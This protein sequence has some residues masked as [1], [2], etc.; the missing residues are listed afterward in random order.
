M[1]QALAEEFLN[2]TTAPLAGIRALAPI[3]AAESFAVSW[4]GSDESGILDYDV[5]V[6]ILGGPWNDWL[7]HTKA[8]TATYTGADGHGF[9]F[10]VRARDTHGNAGV[11]DV[12]SVYHSHVTLAPGAFGKV[13]AA[14]VNVRSAAGTSAPIVTTA[15]SG[16]LLAITGG[17]VTA[18]G[19]TWYRA[20]LPIAEWAPIAGVR[21]DVWVAA[22]N[23]SVTYVAPVSAPNATVVDL[24]S[25]AAP[26]P[27]ARFVG[28]DP[29]RILDTRAGVGLAGTFASGVARTFRV[30]GTHGIPTNA[31]AVTGTLTVVGQSSAG[32]ASLGPSAATVARSSVV[33]VPA[34]DVR[35][36]GVTVKLGADG[37]L[38]ALWTGSA[39]SKS[40]LVFDVS[41]YFVPGATGATFA[42]ITPSRVL[43]TR[44]ANGL[45]GRFA[46]NVP[47]AFLVRGRGGVP[48]GAVAVTGNLTVVGP[49]SAGFL[50]VGP[51]ASTS[52]PGSSLNV[53]KGDIRAASVTVKLDGGGRL[54]VVWKGGPG[55][56][57]DVLFDVTGYFVNGGGGATYHP[58]DAARVLDSR[59]ANGLA[60][61]FQSQ[62]TRTFQATGR[63]TIP[64]NA[65]AVTGGATI[66]SPTGN[67]LLIIGP[68]GT[69][70]GATSTVNLP[71][72][73]I[74]ANGL[75]VRTGPG[76]ALGVVY[77]GPRGAS[78]NVI[79]DATGYFR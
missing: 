47:R 64:V 72:G 29:A 8:T 28:I 68:A 22:G 26:A 63:G 53:P 55:A 38:A 9:A 27:G 51:V 57:A 75:T 15:A 50:Y 76:G 36:A 67:G 39:G 59:I 34:R 65:V 31:V 2:D 32:F 73:D 10:R 79:F 66:V 30:G 25:G 61:A 14:S 20:T 16:T 54:G 44:A 37:S 3:Q 40:S 42:A 52:P 24:P 78:A 56:T 11:W 77:N 19:Y 35:A 13:V 41:G 6:S 5:Q 21:S 23:G 60:G 62:T 1:R 58:I 46:S 71:R 49:S 7:A 33:N 18:D 48:A 70:L 17:P 12:S 74:R 43:D 45:T 69:S 4:A